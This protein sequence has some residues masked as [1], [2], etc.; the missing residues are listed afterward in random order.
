MTAIQ[1]TLIN[2]HTHNGV[3]DQAQI[4]AVFSP[5][6]HLIVEAPAG[7]GKTRTM[8]SKIAYLIA[9]GQILYPKKILALTFSINAAFKIRKDVRDELPAIFSGSPT[10]SQEIEKTVYATNYHGLSRRILHNYGYLISNE[11]SNINDLKGIGISIYDSEAYTTSKF[12]E[13]L[14]NWDI[15]LSSNEIQQLIQYS[16]AIQEAGDKSK[17]SKSNQHLKNN[18]N[19]YLSIVREKFLSKGYILHDAV[20]LFAI[21]LFR[22]HP[23]I[24]DFYRLYFDTIIVDEFQDTN[25]LQWSLLQNLAGKNNEKQNPLFVFGDRNQKI[26]EFIGAMEEI[27]DSAKSIYNMQEIELATNHRFESNSSQLAFDKNLREIIKNTYK[28]NMTINA[29]LKTGYAKDQREETNLILDLIKALVQK[30]KNCTIAILML[31]GKENRNTIEIIKNLNNN[32]LSYFFALY[33]DEDEEYID[34]HQKSFLSLLSHK[35]YAQNFRELA[36]HVKKDVEI[37]NPSETW[38]SLQIL[39]NTLF[40]YVAEEFRMFSIEDKISIIKETLANKALK[41]YLMYVSDTQVTLLTIHGAKGLEWD[42]VILPDMEKN[43]FPSYPGLCI[44]CPYKNSDIGC[45]I[46]WTQ[47]KTT[48]VFHKS[49]IKNLNVFYVGGTRA[50]KKTYFTYSKYGINSKGFPRVNSPSC[51]LQLKGL[52]IHLKKGGL[53]V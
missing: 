26:Y 8:V 40:K 22:K 12:K 16:R 11:L 24:R 19:H 23:Q 42:Y 29:K 2:R 35:E 46:D 38:K 18:L 17:R 49:L 5:A 25:I 15:T 43:S 37:E 48:E 6:P 52:E 10:F 13:N 32:E 20:L 7:Y 47:N 51:F 39:L 34:F 28:P 30:D 27:I 31:A 9:T 41:Q 21:S 45:A 33:G 1:K 4:D 50:R 36:K 44:D 14:A 3:I 53:F